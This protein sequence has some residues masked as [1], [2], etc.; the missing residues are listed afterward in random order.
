MSLS[1]HTLDVFTD[2]P[3]GGNPLAVFPDAPD[4]PTELLQRIAREMNLSETVFVQPAAQ[5][6]ALRRLR[7]FTPSVELPFAGHPTIGAA[8]LLT[9]LGI[10]PRPETKSRFVLEEGVGPIRVTVEQQE[11]SGLFAMLAVAKL[12]EEGPPPPQADLLASVLGLDADQI[13]SRGI[14]ARSFSSGVPYLIVPVRDRAALRQATVNVS[15]WREVLAGYWAPSLYVITRDAELAGSAIRARMFAPAI[16]ISEDPATGAAAAGLIGY[17][18]KQEQPAEGT[19]RWVVE[20]GFEM[21]RPSLIT[22]EADVRGGMVV[23]AR[24]GGSAVRMMDGE[25]RA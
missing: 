7:I 1:F 24:V 11:G 20:Q 12:P 18:T 19:T 21:G 17:L 3:F 13:V 5:A 25:F 4:L 22:L 6:G 14:G 2:R 16:G 10:A 23:E 9:D 15:R 8:I